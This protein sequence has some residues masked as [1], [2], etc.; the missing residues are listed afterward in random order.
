ME[1]TRQADGEIADVDHLLDLA[2]A[3]RQDLARFDRHEHGQVVLVRPQLLAE[4]AHDGAAL[5]A[6]H[7]APGG[8]GGGRALDGAV[9]IVVGDHPTERRTGDRRSR[10]GLG[11]RAVDLHAESKS[12]RPRDVDEIRVGGK[13]HRPIIADS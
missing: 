1:L 5:W 4:F 11:I 10:L 7:G 12:R 8:R 6:G 3:L 9:E 2:E 13:G